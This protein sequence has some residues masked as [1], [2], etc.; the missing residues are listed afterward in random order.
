MGYAGRQVS[1]FIA[2]VCLWWYLDVFGSGATLWNRMIRRVISSRVFVCF[3][4]CIDIYLAGCLS[5]FSSCQRS[6]FVVFF[7]SFSSV[8]IFVTPYLFFLPSSLL[9]LLH[10][11]L[12][13]DFLSVLES[14]SPLSFPSKRRNPSSFHQFSV[15]WSLWLP[16]MIP[17]KNKI[18]PNLP[19]PLSPLLLFPLPIQKCHPIHP[20]L[21]PKPLPLNLF[22]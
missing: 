18:K 6:S 12:A 8:S 19:F 17:I 10:W 20:S 3:F 4:L 13:T 9:E 1:K 21:T 5:L 7:F 15:L 22:V 14:R 16:S 11:I 2:F